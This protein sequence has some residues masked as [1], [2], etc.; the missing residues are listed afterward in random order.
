MKNTNY[1]LI[2]LFV[3]FVL[4]PISLVTPLSIRIK[5][6]IGVVGF[7]YVLGVMSA[8]EKIK[9][10]INKNINWKKFWRLTFMK[11]IGIAVITSLYVLILDSANL[12]NV[13]KH[14][15]RIWL[16]FL[17]VYCVFSVYPQEL[18]FRTFFFKRYEDLFKNKG[19]FIFVNAILFSLAH[20]F[21]RN[22]LVMVIT[23]LGGLLFALTFRK[24]RSTLLVS[25]EH[26]IYGGWLYTIGMGEMLGF[27]V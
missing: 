27:P 14:D 10:H 13:I 19:L 9:I 8:I 5:I 12:F 18:I 16:L 7:L 15:Y 11:F 21:F 17:F 20:L 24:T 4:A 26:A 25:I 2:E 23:F 6:A 1:R 3:I 22:T